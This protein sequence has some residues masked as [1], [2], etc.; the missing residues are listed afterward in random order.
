MALFIQFYKLKS[1]AFLLQ[2]NRNIS[3]ICLPYTPTGKSIEPK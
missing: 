1:V 2:K 3:Y